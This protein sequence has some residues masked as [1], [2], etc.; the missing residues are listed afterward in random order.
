MIESKQTDE[1]MLVS[2]KM[3][4]YEKPE[5][6]TREE[7]GSLGFTPVDDPFNHVR[8]TRAIPLTVIEFGSAQRNFPI[9]FSN[10]QNPVPLAITGI[11]DGNNLFVSAD[12]KWD[13]MAYVP[14]Y[15]RCYPFAFAAEQEGKLAVVVDRAARTVTENP[16]YPFFVDN[17]P[18]EQTESLM[19]FVA[20]YEGQ[21]RRTKEFC[22]RLVELELLDA[23]RATHTP[24]GA[25]EPSPLADYV[26]INVEKLN[27]L[28]AETVFDLHS[29]GFLSAMYMQLYSIENWRHLMARQVMR[30]AKA[31]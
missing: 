18:S 17:E 23:Q 30:A 28:D 19:R 1:P 3:F 14:S 16:T 20:T 27:A 2:G 5:L 22:D 7:H 12:G 8:N 21:R 15:L 13:S 4:L 6:L 31:A 9:I 26:S 25:D 10:L 11:T 29:K 24:E